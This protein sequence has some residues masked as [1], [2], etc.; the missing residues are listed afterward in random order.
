LVR[1]SAHFGKQLRFQIQINS[2]TCFLPRNS[3]AI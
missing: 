3:L 2:H 1:G